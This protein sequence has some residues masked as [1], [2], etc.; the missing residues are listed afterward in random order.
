L[1]IDFGTWDAYT[2]AMVSHLT[3]D[4]RSRVFAEEVVRRIDA[5]PLHAAV[6]HARELCGKWRLSAPSKDLETWSRILTQPWTEIRKVLLDPAEHGTRLRQSNPFCGVLS[7]QE[8]WRIYKGFRPL[9]GP[10]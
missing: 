5:D 6:T 2:F 4:E 1:G 10:R 8:R 9:S 7:P 3:I